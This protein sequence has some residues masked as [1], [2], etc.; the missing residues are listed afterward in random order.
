[1]HNMEGPWRLAWLKAPGGGEIPLKKD[2]GGYRGVC[3]TS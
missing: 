1:M 3:H 2:R